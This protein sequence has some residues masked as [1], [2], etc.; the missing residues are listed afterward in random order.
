[1]KLRI[2]TRYA[3]YTSVVL[4]LVVSLALAAAGWASYRQAATLQPE[5]RAALAAAHTVDREEALLRGGRYLSNRLFNPLYSLDVSRL[6]EE[7][8]QVRTWLPVE[9]LLVL[10]ANGRVVTRT[11][12][13]RTAC[14]AAWSRCRPDCSRT[15]R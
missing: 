14:T 12:P 9:S 4:V 15:S 13:R 11:A 2:G 7:I 5:L 3:L 6:N 1:M 10:D 8:E